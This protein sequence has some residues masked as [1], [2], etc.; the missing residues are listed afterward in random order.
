M[1]AAGARFLA[2]AI[3]NVDGLLFLARLLGLSDFPSVLAVHDNVFFADDQRRVDDITAAELYRHGYIDVDGNVDP[4][5]R[6]WLHVL[7][8]P[9]IYVG[10]RAMEGSRMRRAVVARQGQRHVLALRRN[11]GIA[12]QAVWAGSG[13]LDDVV[14]AP[15]WAA[16]R[17]V[18]DQPDPTPAQ[19]TPLTLPLER[20]EVLAQG[21]P[22]QMVRCLTRAGFDVRSARILNEV[23]QY[24]EVSGHGGQRAEIVLSVNEG[25]RF[26]DTPA[27][28]S[29]AD[30]S[31]GRVIF[32]PKKHQ[33]NLVGAYFPGNRAHFRDAIEG[34]VNLTQKR[35]WFTTS[36]PW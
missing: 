23:S 27:A 17:P 9:D 21:Q 24:G 14:A 12:V 22:G 8:A 26:R 15:L 13:R 30:T 7:A 10:M 5:L 32:A 28:V 25:I 6:T 4:E 2:A 19:I 20:F 11:D 16:L 1:I 35:D 18:A 3:L 34:L 29:V 33:K 31:F 36:L